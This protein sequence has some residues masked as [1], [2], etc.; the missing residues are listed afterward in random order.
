[1]IQRSAG[2]LRGEGFRVLSA[3]FRGFRSEGFSNV[4][5]AT[6]GDRAEATG[7]FGYPR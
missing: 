1:M 2:V 6:K 4:G 3:A 5:L 7:P